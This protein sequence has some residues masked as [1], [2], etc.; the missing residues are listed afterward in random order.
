M[1]RLTESVSPVITA[2]VEDRTAR[3]CAH[4][5]LRGVANLHLGNRFYGV[6]AHAPPL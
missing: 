5:I 6:Q 2:Q 1:K 3:Q 4:N